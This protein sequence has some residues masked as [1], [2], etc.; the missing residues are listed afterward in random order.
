MKNIYDGTV[1]TDGSGVANVEMP[2]YFD[3][4]N[5]DF[6]YQL[7]VIGEFAQAIVG[8]EINNNQ[9]SIMTDKPN[10]KVSWQVT[11]IR[12]D[13]YANANRI[14]VEE[15]KKPEERGKYLHPV[16]FGKPHEMSVNYSAEQE[17][18]IQRMDEQNRLQT[19]RNDLEQKVYQEQKEMS[20][21]GTVLKD[22]R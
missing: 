6:R 14:Q 10:V 22:H 4:L 11:G 16:A 19:E 9:F 18:E 3:A 8:E 21:T 17:A 7:T 15:D 13:A 1:I 20:T 5:R 12:Q 2:E